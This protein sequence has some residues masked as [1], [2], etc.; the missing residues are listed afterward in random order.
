MDA[1]GIQSVFSE[2]DETRASI[3]KKQNRLEATLAKYPRFRQGIFHMAVTWMQLGREKEAL[4]YL[5]K[6]ADLNPEDPTVHYYLAAIHFQR[7]N[8]NQAWKYLRT[9]E[10]IVHRKEHDPKA[11]VE[12]RRALQRKCPETT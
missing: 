6:C 10:A 8:F 11:L 3:F 7:H 5:E 9:S 2:V 4:P 1:E 12:L